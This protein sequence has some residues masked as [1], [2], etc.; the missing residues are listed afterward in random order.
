MRR[1]LWVA[2]FFVAGIILLLSL[3]LST[4][5]AEFSRYNTGW[6]GT[7]DLFATLEERGAVFVTDPQQLDGVTGGLLLVIA[8]DTKFTP[9][10]GER[11]RRFVT[12]GNTLLVA[13]D[14]GTGN[15]LLSGL[16]TEIRFIVRNLSSMDRA[17]GDPGSVIGYPSGNH[18]LLSGVGRVVLDRPSALEKGD[19][20]IRTSMLSWL[21]AG[22]KKGVEFG[23]YVVMSED[24]IG[25]GELLAL[26]DGSVF[27]NGMLRTGENSRLIENILVYRDTLLVDQTHSRTAD[28]GGFIS[29]LHV[30]RGEILFRVIV[31][32]ALCTMIAIFFR[33][34]RN[35]G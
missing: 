32:C 7:S 23:K 27:I 31:I 14:F 35:G 17:T 16:D 19:P 24:R 20:L 5:T 25:A 12:S 15:T 29:I 3:H 8:P 33:R 30:V 2:A 26:S 9:E 11:Y 4:T 28:T 34:G 18:T 10:E 21:D 1:L 22:G 6:N 13:D